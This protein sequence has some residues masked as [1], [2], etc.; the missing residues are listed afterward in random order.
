MLNAPHPSHGLGTVNSV[1]IVRLLV[2]AANFIYAYLCVRPS[3]S[4]DVEFAVCAN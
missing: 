4:G 2:Q 1:N 3:A